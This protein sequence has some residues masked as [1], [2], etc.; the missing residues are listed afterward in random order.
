M[1]TQ[2]ALL[3]CLEQ[4]D[5]WR[6]GRRWLAETL[7]SSAR[8]QVCSDRV[9]HRIQLGATTEVDSRN[10]AAARP[11]QNPL[12]GQV[13]YAQAKVAKS[14]ATATAIGLMRRFMVLRIDAA[15]MTCARS[16]DR[17]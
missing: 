2:A 6:C 17:I 15:G 13:D 4:L 8:G 10:D 11:P 7:N 16:K 3:T 12:A 14:L 9:S 1:L 5:R